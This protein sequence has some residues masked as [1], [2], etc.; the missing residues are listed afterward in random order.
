MKEQ[1]KDLIKQAKLSHFQ[2]TW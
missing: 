1:K 2:E